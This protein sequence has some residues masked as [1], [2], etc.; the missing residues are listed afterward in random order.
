[1]EARS[2]ETWW[3]GQLMGL[4]MGLSG[5]SDLAVHRR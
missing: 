1:M 2:L 5:T 4:V 3:V